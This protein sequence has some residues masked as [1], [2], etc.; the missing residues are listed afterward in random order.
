MTTALMQSG[1]RL[2]FQ[3]SSRADFGKHIHSLERSITRATRQE[4]NH[5]CGGCAV[6][7]MPSALSVV[8]LGVLCVKFRKVS[9]REHKESRRE[10]HFRLG[11]ARMR[12][13][14]RTPASMASRTRRTSAS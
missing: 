10:E 6:R 11:S 3:D 8:F 12:R 5:D 14:A 1:W 7:G 2:L 13:Q 9:Y 4:V